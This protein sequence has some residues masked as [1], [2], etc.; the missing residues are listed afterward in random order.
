MDEWRTKKRFPLTAWVDV[1]VKESGAMRRGYVTN[2]SRE[3]VGLYY[4]GTIGPGTSVDL[5]MHMLGPT[6]TEIIETVQGR[7]MWEDHWGGITIMGIKF[8]EPLGSGTPIIVERLTRAERMEGDRPQTAGVHEKKHAW[9]VREPD[10]PGED[11][12]PEHA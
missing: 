1:T 7:V 2:I 5:T 8:D 11:T 9:Q 6:G 10:V 12:V 3:G 4:L